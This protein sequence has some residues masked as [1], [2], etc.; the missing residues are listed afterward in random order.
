MGNWTK[1][2]QIKRL[3]AILLAAVLMVPNV[4]VSVYAA[5][6]ETVVETISETEETSEVTSSVTETEAEEV[7]SVDETTSEDSAEEERTSSIEET[8]EQEPVFEEEST[9]ETTSE[10]E[11]TA[12][13]TTEE[14]TEEITEETTVE[15][16]IE[17]EIVID[18]VEYIVKATTE[19]NVVLEDP[20]G[21]YQLTVKVT[22][23]TV[24]QYAE[25]NSFTD[26]GT[27]SSYAVTIPATVPY[28]DINVKVVGILKS[29]FRGQTCISSVYF[30]E[31]SELSY[32]NRDVFNGCTSL[33]YI[34]PFPETLTY[35]GVY[36]FSDCELLGRK[37]KEGN[38]I[39]N[40]ELVLPSSLTG[41][42][43]ES[44]GN[45]S[46]KKVTIPASFNSINTDT[47]SSNSPFYSCDNLTDIIIEEGVQTIP[48]FM[49]ARNISDSLS[50]AIPDSV[51]YIGKNAFIENEELVSL[52]FGENS[53]LT[54][55]GPYA[56]KNCNKL[57]N[58]SLPSGV[59]TL[60]KECFTGCDSL[61]KIVI[62]KSISSV[63]TDLYADGG[64]FYLCDNLT[65]ISFEDGTTVIPTNLFLGQIATADKTISIE[66]P[67]S[68]INISG[69][70]FYNQTNLVSVIFED[71]SQI[72]SIGNSAFYGC[73]SLKYFEFAESLSSIGKQTFYGCTLLGSVNDKGEESAEI[74]FPSTLTTIGSEAFYGCSSLEKIVIPKSLTTV[75]T[76]STGPFHGCDNLTDI[77]FEE[78]IT[79]IPSNLFNGRTA[80]EDKIISIEIPDSVITIADKAFY[81]QTN[82][83]AVSFGENSALTTIGTDAFCFCT[84]LGTYDGEGNKLDVP[85]I[86]L[87]EG[88]TTIGKNAFYQ[89]TLVE[90]IVLPKTLTTVNSTTTGPF[91]KCD[92]LSNIVLQEG[93]TTIPAYLFSGVIVSETTDELTGEFLHT[94]SFDIPDT[95][96]TIETAAFQNQTNLV[97]VNFG[98]NSV[99]RTIEDYAFHKASLMENFKMPNT[100]KT[101]GELAFYS[102]SNLKYINLPDGI[103]T[104]GERAFAY[105]P[106]MLSL[107]ENGNVVERPVLELPES[108]T[109]IGFRAFAGNN[110]IK[111]IYIPKSLT[112]YAA[113]GSETSGAFYKFT[114]LEN[115]VFEEGRTEIPNNLLAG[116]DGDVAEENS[117]YYNILFPS[118]L[119]S[120]PTKLCV[121]NPYVGSISFA[122]NSKLQSIGPYAF[123]ECRNLKSVEFPASLKLIE[124]HAFQYASSLK[125][126][127]FPENLTSIE[128]YALSGCTGLQ[129]VEF[130][131][132]NL[133][134]HT[135][136]LD[137]YVFNGC[138]AL[139]DVKFGNKIKTIPEGTFY[140]CTALEEVVFS[141]GI[142]SIA[143]NVFYN[144]E[145]LRTIFIPASVTSIKIAPSELAYCYEQGLKIYVEKGN[146]T[147]KTFA[148]T[149]GYPV[150]VGIYAT[151]D[152]FSDT[153]LLEQ[154][155]KQLY[156]KN[157]DTRLT[158]RELEQIVDVDLSGLGIKDMTGTQLFT[159][160]ETLDCS[161]NE[162]AELDTATWTKLVSLDCSGNKIKDL[163][164]SN[165]PIETLDCSNNGILV[166]DLSDVETLTNVTLGVQ[167]GNL[168]VE[169]N[170]TYGFYA[171]PLP[172]EYPAYISDNLSEV[173]D[174]DAQKPNRYG[175]VWPE[176]YDVP[177]TVQYRY[178]TTYGAD[179]TLVEAIVRVIIP[180]AGIEISSKEYPDP[181]F[182]KR[183]NE[184]VDTN[185]N[186]LISK[187]EERNCT[188][189][190]VS[191]SEGYEIRDLTGV[192]RLYNLTELICKNNE[193]TALDV[194]KNTKLVTLDCSNNQIKELSVSNNPQL[195]SLT[196]S[197]NK[198]KALSTSSNPELVTLVCADNQIATFDLAANNNLEVFECGN[199]SL[200]AINLTEN[201]AL[202][203]VLL[204]QQNLMLL[205]EKQDNLVYARVR[206]YD[207]AF[208]SNKVSDVVVYNGEEADT[209][210]EYIQL[211]EEGFVVEPLITKVTYKYTVPGY[212]NLFVNM[213]LVDELVEEEE[214]ILKDI[215]E[216]DIDDFVTRIYTGEET[217]QNIVIMDGTYMLREYVDYEVTYKDNI[218][219]GT[220]KVEIEGI[221]DYRG[222]Y[223]NTYEIVNEWDVTIKA[224][225]DQTYQ[226][227]KIEPKLTV[228][229]GRKTLRAG[230]DYKAEYLNNKNTGVATVIITGFGPYADAGMKEI[231]FNIV[232]CKIS[233]AKF[234]ADPV[235]YNGTAQKPVVTAI[236]NNAYLKEG[237]D[238]KT[239][240][241]KN[242]KAGKGTITITGIGNYTGTV[243][244]TFMINKIDLA[245][246]SDE[247]IIIDGPAKYNMTGAKVGVTVKS[248][249]YQLVEG[250]DYTLSYSKNKAVGTA[251][252]TIKGKGS[253]KNKIVKDFEIKAQSISDPS[254]SIDVAI[255]QVDSRG[256]ALKPKVTITQNK[257]KLREGEKKDY[258]ISYDET[259]TTS[260]GVYTV[261]IY[262]KNNFGGSEEGVTKEF[263]I[264][265]QLINKAKVKG[266]QNWE[267]DGS[268]KE[269][270]EEM[271]DVMV[272]KTE[273]PSS[274]YELSYDN[275]VNVGTAVMTIKVDPKLC[276]YEFGGSTTAK[277][278]ITAVK[279]KPSKTVQ[280][281]TAEFE[282]MDYT[283]DTSVPVVTYTGSA[284]SPEVLV[285]DEELGVALTEGTD[286][287]V[288]YKNNVKVGTKASA[289]IK[290]IKNYSGSINL[291]FAVVAKDMNE[292]A[293]DFSVSVK[294]SAYTGKNI[295]PRV[296]V[297]DGDTV[298]KL[299]KDYVL[300]IE[301]Y[302][303][304]DDF[305]GNIKDKGMYIITIEG[306][307]NYTGELDELYYLSVY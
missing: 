299:N 193:L 95:V 46:F 273:V 80:S 148:E 277:F 236:H 183:I 82:L 29:S 39:E 128:Q 74:M 101:I 302:I 28:N 120:I 264:V 186:G 77:T 233:K 85:E 167:N 230:I 199:N 294:N 9:F 259:A 297:W 171:L 155:R 47:Y 275:N 280:R 89:C 286:Y 123:R 303:E 252:V 152:E 44:F 249:D 116:V 110:T 149:N 86:F 234:S 26:L 265:G 304:T 228:K 207:P 58:I 50:I 42:G 301:Q 72:S 65:D 218:E 168:A 181:D 97:A 84:N 190:D 139:K 10:E 176:A 150:E 239:V 104:I 161:D 66:I 146:S 69:S 115:V 64:P 282:N 6:D 108:L 55:I 105:I 52:N 290:G 2:F 7:E 135:Q 125:N 206:E 288:T 122:E 162:I 127:V 256:K 21:N 210:G 240:Y 160:M 51:T 274:C 145:S 194:S 59:T 276:D 121:R 25:I 114:Q 151:E 138:S 270:F 195:F 154:M 298:L 88:L 211:T 292:H 5:T 35:I 182:R 140:N 177:D 175:I 31:G 263:V 200:A 81:N 112:T 22:D 87:P 295:K 179:N 262:G 11:T 229:A 24:T 18:E 307:G 296:I 271:I 93:I 245:K 62:P 102:C 201:D 141:H 242:I 157:L 131:V 3:T 71:N 180:N 98:E 279:F 30:E 91:Y 215:A 226:N 222:S 111:E 20:N 224:I 106:D 130:E 61:Q 54:S 208:D 8:T 1:L 197:K 14:T 132:H 266:L 284:L 67:A 48:S 268:E 90:K 49:F 165:N 198:I 216:L 306:K 202:V 305:K 103:T 285:Y 75:N 4:P 223:E 251:K 147:A 250:T 163:D 70:A 96:I 76:S 247:D 267:Y 231:T 213:N 243:K 34:D 205:K 92:N 187:V 238:F 142:T 13:E 27:S 220:A 221:G 289:I 153:A 225:K 196:C 68:V 300:H 189:L 53:A 248:G 217:F 118:S 15:V 73:T 78:G 278:K 281:V 45:T 232:E 56:F 33:S 291:N 79:V 36:C 178:K 164:F 113:T 209:S 156:D 16:T 107:D 174:E 214:I 235:T 60:G 159:S 129:S 254:I 272:G 117:S 173:S 219:V 260:K 144:C 257:K 100:V 19:T 293:D 126:V 166:F 17:E 37:D 188:R 244:K 185:K 184:Q 237:R 137:K 204:G 12:V 255:A 287:T 258:V 83:V 172:T 43:V 169:E 38:N 134:S 23:D 40:P 143:K 261:T 109:T 253:C 170:E 241:S 203:E 63:T 191:G 41:L 227:K 124:D 158:L 192:E 119:V 94:I 136:S 212:G 57:E 246:L 133:Y 283:D 99:L 269:Q 32:I